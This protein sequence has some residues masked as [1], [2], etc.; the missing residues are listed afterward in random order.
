MRAWPAV[1]EPD[2]HLTEKEAE[3]RAEVT[4][5][6]ATVGGGRAGVGSGLPTPSPELF[7][8]SVSGS[9]LLHCSLWDSALFLLQGQGGGPRHLTSSSTCL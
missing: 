6:Q 1:T 3:A 5:P 2:P 9:S 7:C 4:C 8:G